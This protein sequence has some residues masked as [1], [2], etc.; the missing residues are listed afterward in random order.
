[1]S[2][3]QGLLPACVS[4]VHSLGCVNCFF[5]SENVRLLSVVTVLC[6]G[7]K[8]LYREGRG[9]V[10]RGGLVTL[11][12]IHLKLWTH[13]EFNTIMFSTSDSVSSVKGHC[14]NRLCMYMYVYSY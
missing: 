6:A 2:C 8:V 5:H 1:M 7:A 10:G 12:S 14:Y 4:I 13:S 3:Q 9:R 11:E